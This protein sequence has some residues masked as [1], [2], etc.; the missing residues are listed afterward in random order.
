[1]A[2]SVKHP[3]LDFGS[4]HDLTVRGT[5]PLIGVLS[6]S[7]SAPPPHTL[8]IKKIQKN[9]CKKVWLNIFSCLRVFGIPFSVD[10]LC[11]PSAQVSPG[12]L[13]FHTDL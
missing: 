7:L 5:E 10:Y 9:N 2:Q 4:G 8:K 6:L 1:M 12:F 11:R 3:A 13:V